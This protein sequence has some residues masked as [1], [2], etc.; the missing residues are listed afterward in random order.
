MAELLEVLMKPLAEEA[1]CGFLE[2]EK[3]LSQY[4]SW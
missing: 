1:G 4:F 2:K 3:I